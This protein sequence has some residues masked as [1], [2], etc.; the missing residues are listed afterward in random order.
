MQTENKKQGKTRKKTLTPRREKL[1]KELAN[2]E[3][4]SVA[5]AAR[6]AGFA[7]SSINSTVYGIVRDPVISEAIEKR[8]RRALAHHNV[9]PEEVIG[10]AVF[11]M[12]SSMDDVLDEEGSFSMEKARETGAVDLLKK[13]KETI[14]TVY[15]TETKET[16][17][18]KT[19]EVELLTNQ[20]AR[21]E[22][23]NYI[24]LEKSPQLPIKSFTD[25]ELARELFQRLVEKRGWDEQEA[26]EGV[27]ERFPDVDIKLLNA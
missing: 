15:R 12:R 24:G 13:H 20:D 8:R 11:Q 25:E 17:T 2:P 4:K 5:E 19:I 18:T 7:P 9:T 6:K 22:V 21:K 16:E 1:V 23:A 10:S 3:T 14:K 26:M 27:R